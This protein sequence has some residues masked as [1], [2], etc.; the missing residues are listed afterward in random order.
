LQCLPCW[1]FSQ[2]APWL[3]TLTP[4][5]RLAFIQLIPIATHQKSLLKLTSHTFSIS[6]IMVTCMTAIHMEA[7]RTPCTAKR[8]AMPRIPRAMAFRR[9]CACPLCMT[10]ASM[11][12]IST[13]TKHQEIH[14][15]RRVLNIFIIDTLDLSELFTN[16]SRYILEANYVIDSL[17]QKIQLHEFFFKYFFRFFVCFSILFGVFDFL[18]FLMILS[19]FKYFAANSSI[20]VSSQIYI[21]PNNFHFNQFY[22]W[23]YNKSFFINILWLEK[24]SP[25]NHLVDYYFMIFRFSFYDLKI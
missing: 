22:L 25:T 11:I 18:F 6:A 15:M 4:R 24:L 12:P 14:Q 21:V 7:S 2:L 20:F 5:W 23:K 10:T 17:F 19:N 3:C 8:T 16:E 9:S 13:A 1:L